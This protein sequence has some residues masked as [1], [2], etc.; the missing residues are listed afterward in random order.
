MINGLKSVKLIEVIKTEAEI[1]SGTE[2]DPVRIAVQYW[3]LNGKLLFIV[4]SY[5]QS[6]HEKHDN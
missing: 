1:G 5:Y 2:K 6:D 3:D 4:D